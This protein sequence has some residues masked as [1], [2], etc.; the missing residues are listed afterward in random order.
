LTPTDHLY[1]VP[2]ETS[3]KFSLLILV[4]FCMQILWENFRALVATSARNCA[5]EQ[6][7]VV[8]ELGL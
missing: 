3:N 7:L 2:F 5:I 4:E 8:V 1:R 6:L